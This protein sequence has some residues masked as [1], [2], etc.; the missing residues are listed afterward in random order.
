LLVDTDKIGIQ[1]DV[2]EDITSVWTVHKNLFDRESE[3]ITCQDE[4]GWSENWYVVKK[5]NE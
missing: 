4:V 2:S 3:G 1:Y 5:N